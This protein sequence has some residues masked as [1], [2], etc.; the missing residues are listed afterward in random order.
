M[1][2]A[3]E[4][5]ALIAADQQTARTFTPL[6]RESGITSQETADTMHIVEELDRTKFEAI[7]LD[8]AVNS[9]AL[10]LLERVRSNPAN[11]NTVIFAIVN[12]SASRQEAIARGANFVF[13]QPLDA[14]DIRN[15][16]RA[17]RDLMV[18]ERRRYFRCTAEIPVLLMEKLSGASFQC[19]SMNISRSGMAVVT[20]A[21]LGTGVEI[22]LQWFLAGKRN[23]IRASGTVVW[24]DKHGKSGIS[25]RCLNA[26][27]QRDLDSW[28]DKQFLTLSSS[29]GSGSEVS[30]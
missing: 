9:G 19:T 27:M 26:K 24:D 17:A 6:F 21:P 3:V 5:R 15:V 2:D 30:P 16:V 8:F 18:R 10:G 14:E 11:R 29:K 25:F 1:N 28:L 23:A 12:G 7:V 20:P 4:I 22:E 13:E